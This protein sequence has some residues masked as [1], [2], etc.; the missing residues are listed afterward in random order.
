MTAIFGVA[1]GAFPDL[2]LISELG[3]GADTVVYRVRRQGRDYALKLMTRAGGDRALTAIR[4]EA[5]LMGCVGHPLLPKIF[6]VGQVEAGPYL[7][8]EYIDG[9]PLSQVLQDG[10]LDPERAV[11]LAIDVLA[12]LAAAHRTG[13]VHR[14]VKPDNVIVCTD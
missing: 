1:P 2:E 7:I 8:L 4:R 13:L 3:R 12:P 5:A 6:E 10:A 14:D 11:R 9:P